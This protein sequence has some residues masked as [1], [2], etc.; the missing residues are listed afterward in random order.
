MKKVSIII[1]NYNNGGYIKECLDSV[2]NQRYL[3][4]EIIVVDD[5]SSDNSV[6]I[7]QECVSKHGCVKLYTT[8]HLGPNA[9]RKLGLEK[10]SGKYVMFVDSD[11]FLKAG[12]IEVLVEKIEHNDVDVVRF[13]SE[14]CSDKKKVAPILRD[15][16]IERM[17]YRDDIA[18]L[19]TTGFKLT[20]VWSKIYRKSLFDNLDIFDLDIS[21]GEDLLMSVETLSKLDKILLASDILYYYRDDNNNSLTHFVEKQR[22]IKNIKDRVFVSSVMLK[23]IREN[24]FETEVKQRAIYEQV[25]AIWEAIRRLS[26]VE[27]YKKKDFAADFVDCFSSLDL[28]DDDF[29][30][31][32]QYVRKMKILDRLKKGNVVLDIARNDIDGIWKNFLKY[33][34]L[35]K[36]VR[37]GK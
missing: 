6:R 8:N 24:I 33:K 14:R 15:D 30:E 11:D 26:L 5:G 35:R 20:S 4:K 29:E 10:A 23:F 34:A 25:K 3:E 7:I 27:D 28:T 13:E 32:S 19:L 18:K 2:L 12:A 16:E 36:V 17:I 21:F 37:R 9:A 31:L 1:T 22:I